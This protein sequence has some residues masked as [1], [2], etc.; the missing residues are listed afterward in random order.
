MVGGSIKN[1]MAAEHLKMPDS[2]T[3]F[4]RSMNKKQATPSEEWLTR[5]V[6][7]TAIS[8]LRDFVHSLL[9]I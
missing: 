7:V 9:R 2:E 8:M 3:P 1:G 4:V 6:M 5:P